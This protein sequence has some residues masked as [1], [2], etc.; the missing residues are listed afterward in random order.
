[1]GKPLASEACKIHELKNLRAIHYLGDGMWEFRCDVCKWFIEIL[2]DRITRVS[3]Q[4]RAQR[5]R[6]SNVRS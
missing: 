1:M 6:R 4:S 3:R 2:H 5:T